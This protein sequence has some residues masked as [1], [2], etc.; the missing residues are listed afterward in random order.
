MDDPF[1]EKLHIKAT[2][3]FS[4]FAAKTFMET[5]SDNPYLSEKL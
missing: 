1:A 5:T 2:F 3:C 4:R